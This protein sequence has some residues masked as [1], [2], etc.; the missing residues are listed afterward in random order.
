MGK[1]EIP[2]STSI[3]ML[4][5]DTV[6]SFKTMLKARYVEPAAA[7]GAST[8][9]ASYD[10]FNPARI[11]EWR[12]A[13]RR[14]RAIYIE[15]HK[16]RKPRLLRPDRFTE[17]MQWRKLFDLNPVYAVLSDKLAVRDFIAERVGGDVLIPLLWVGTDPDA[18]PFDA[19]DPPYV[20]KSTHASRQVL[21]VRQRADVDTGAAV[22]M[23][24][25]W[26]A[27][28]YGTLHNE[29]GY[30][31]VPRRLMVERMLLGTD[32]SSPLEHRLFLFD[33][34]VRFVQTTVADEDGF[35]HRAFH[36]REWR[37]LDWYLR[38]PNQPELCPRP[39]RYEEIIALAECLGKGFDHLRVDVYDGH[40][41]IWVG[42][43]TLY[44]WGGLSPFT[45]DQ[46]DKL[47]GSY[48]SL[49]RPARRALYAMLWQWREIRANSP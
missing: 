42:E 35:H 26:L 27:S 5:N 40:D 7:R 37:P 32:G 16:G 9:N 29:P 48:W 25:D 11:Y 46:A 19:L 6:R 31:P 38:T 12:A 20:I 45:P 17:K 10:V 14:V 13:M 22:A 28:C 36:D 41:S 47:V 43:L 44:S 8:V 2:N 33:G 49:Q 34:R 18:V 23:F 3:S 39:K 24:K 4:L 21:L 30:V 15:K 1:L